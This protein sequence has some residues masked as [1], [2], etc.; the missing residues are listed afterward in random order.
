MKHCPSVQRGFTLIEL[1]IVVAIIGILAAVA[2]P[3]YQDYTVKAKIT[4]GLSVA[5]DAK[6][7]VSETW[8]ANGNL[9]T[10]DAAHQFVGNGACAS[11]MLFCFAPTKNVT[12]VVID[13]AHGEV[14]VTYDFSAT[15]INQLTNATNTLVLVPTIGGA[16]LAPQ[17]AGTM[18]WHCKSAAST[19]GIGTTG[20][21][22]GRYSP[23][24]C[25]GAV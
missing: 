5:S 10:L 16:A 12:S 17:V 11:T 15:G 18:D 1:M 9:V 4:E 23:T 13:S 24:Q 19:F 22:P 6:A 20:T 7:L 25:R 2:L 8:T 3:A 14:T 21:L